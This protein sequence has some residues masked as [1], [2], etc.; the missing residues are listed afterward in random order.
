[1]K[2]INCWHHLLYACII[3]FFATNKCQKILK[4]GKNGW[5]WWSKLSYFLNDLLSFSKIFRKTSG[6]HPLSRKLNFEKNTRRRIKVT[7][8]LFRI[9]EK[10]SSEIFKTLGLINNMSNI[11]RKN[12]PRIYIKKYRRNE[13]YFIKEFY[14][15]KVYWMLSYF[16]F[17]D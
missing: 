8:R 7:P 13:N 4:I 5:Y 16:S 1:M 2:Q 9:G 10:E 6:L 15:L 17:S 14:N 3:G 12:K 11:S